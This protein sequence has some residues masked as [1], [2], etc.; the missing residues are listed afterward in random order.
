MLVVFGVALGGI[1]A[2][3]LSD[4]LERNFTRTLVALV[5][6][7]YK[8][9]VEEKLELFVESLRVL[10]QGRVLRAVVAVTALVWVVEAVAYWTLG[11]AFGMDVAPPFYLLVVAI[12]NLGVAIP[13]S[14]GAIGPFEFFV[15][16]T[17][18]IFDVSSSRG[19]AYAVCI[20]GISLAFVVGSGLLFVGWRGLR[21]SPSSWPPAPAHSGRSGSDGGAQIDHSA[22]AR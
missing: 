21:A 20:H 17:L 8:G 16:Q 18:I 14:V 6:S 1:A 11:E 15:Q 22:C 12:G 4:R 3:A 9:P 7:R 10:R 5:P 13:F 2:L 19:L